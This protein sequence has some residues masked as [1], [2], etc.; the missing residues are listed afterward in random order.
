MALKSGSRDSPVAAARCGCHD[1]RM[2]D[3]LARA[4]GNL[5]L[6][7]VAV[8]V[9]LT[10]A[11]MALGWWLENIHNGLLAVTFTLVGAYIL[12]QRPR[13]REG[14]LFMATG[15]VHAVMFFGR[16]LGHFMPDASAW[17]GWLGVWPLAPALLLTTL[18]VICFPDG[19][20]PSRIWRPIVGVLIADTALLTLLSLIW[21]VGYPMA[22]LTVAHPL[23][24]AA[25][26]IAQ[27]LWNA[28]AS[29]SFVLFQLLWVVSLVERWVRRP[30]IVRR[31]VAWLAAAA[32]ISVALLVVGLLV[33]GSPRSGV[34]AATLLPLAAGWAIVHGQHVAAYSALSWLSRGAVDPDALPTD[35]ARAVGD[36]IESERVS[37]WLG[38]AD[39]LH[40]VGEWPAS[41]G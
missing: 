20:L 36:A 1:E 14:I 29:P 30:G 8:A 15:I 21:P 3:V 39:R 32:A 34:L 22:G 24:E 26:P 4:R 33:S 11:G 28:T 6:A 2:A 38:D 16:Q 12:F 31:Q 9:I 5:P 37:I 10:A 18:S 13:H 23:L 40:L 19:R 25:P 17:W 41:Q 7:L 35:M 27:Q